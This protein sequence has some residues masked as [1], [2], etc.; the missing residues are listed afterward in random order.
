MSIPGY[1][2][3]AIKQFKRPNLKKTDSPIIYVPPRYGKHQQE[4]HPEE[5]STALSPE[6]LKELQEIVGVFLFYAR[7]VDPTMFTAINKIASH[8]S[9]PASHIKKE[10]ERFLEYANKWS[11]A[12][13][14]VRSS[15][16]ILQC[17]SDGS[18]FSESDARSRA[19][20][21]YQQ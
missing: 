7:V 8:Q 14:K 18:Y 5:P 15:N 1:V 12:T 17:H 16:M 6:E 13:L 21:S 11:D 10:V 2:K 4:V 3:K 19:G 9:K 20:G